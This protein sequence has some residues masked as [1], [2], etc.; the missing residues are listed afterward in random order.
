[1]QWCWTAGRLVDGTRFHA[2]G[3]FVPGVDLGIGYVLAPGSSHFDEV[4]EVSVAADVGREGLVD[5]AHL[6]FAG[7]EVDVEPVAWSPVLLAHPDGREARFPRALAR[8]RLADGRRGVGW[9]EFNQPPA[10][11]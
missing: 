6:R 7:W 11:S 8:F 2:V 3:G 10:G 9:I 4:A 1:M 5:R